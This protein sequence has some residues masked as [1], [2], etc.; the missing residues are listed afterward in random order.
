MAKNWRG[1]AKSYDCKDNMGTVG[2]D[3][4]SSPSHAESTCAT[5]KRS[6]PLPSVGKSDR[7]EK[8]E[9]HQGWRGVLP[10]LPLFIVAGGIDPEK[11][12]NATRPHVCTEAA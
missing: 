8:G 11:R 10:R 7:N 5:K 2:E 3:K 6:P 12:M 9:R 1:N 4:E